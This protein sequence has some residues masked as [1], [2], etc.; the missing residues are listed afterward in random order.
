MA[1]SCDLHLC[2]CEKYTMGLPWQ[3]HRSCLILPHWTHLH[4]HRFHPTPPCPSHLCLRLLTHHLITYYFQTPITSSLLDVLSL[5]TSVPPPRRSQ[6]PLFLPPTVTQSFDYILFC[7][8]ELSLTS[9]TSL[10]LPVKCVVTGI[11]YACLFVGYV[12]HSLFQAYIGPIPNSFSATLIII[13]GLPPALLLSG[14]LSPFLISLSL[15]LDRLHFLPPW[16][17][18]RC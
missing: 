17:L 1:I 9:Q 2:K 3:T 18:Q 10:F 11:C 7:L 14:S 12:E 8:T 5:H 16:L 13:L 15:S 4:I 6:D